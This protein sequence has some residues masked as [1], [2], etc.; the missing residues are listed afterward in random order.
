MAAVEECEGCGKE[1]G[2]M[3]IT[4]YSECDTEYVKA[5]KNCQSLNELKSIVA[6]YREICEDAYQAVEK[7]DDTLFE[8]F[9]KGR[10]KRK[11]SLT[12]MEMYG[13][14]LLPKT[15][16]EVGLVACQ[17]HIP[18]GTAYHRMKDMGKIS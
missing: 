8:Q 13:A 7:M 17:F 3:K 10:N 11:P 12:W 15:I 2:D 1:G 16:L 6:E 9:C 14:I 5:V 4:Y 18:F